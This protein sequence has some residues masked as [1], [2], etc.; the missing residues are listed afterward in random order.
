LRCID[1]ATGQEKWN[2]AYDAP[3]KISHNGSRTAPTVDET[4]VYSVGMM[5]HFYCIDRTTHQPVWAKNLLSDFGVSKPGWG[6]V[7]APS[8]YGDLVIVAPQAADAY[9][10]A[11]NK[12]TGDLVW[13]SAALGVV[14]YSTPVVARLSGVDQAVMVGACTKG[15]G[16]PAKVGGVSLADGS[17]LWTYDGFQCHIPIPYPAVLPDDRLF[18]TGGYGAGSAMI[19]VKLEGEQWTVKELFK[20]EECASQTHQPLFYKDHL[21]VNSNSNEREDGM[22]CLTMDGQVK[23]KTGSS[24][25]ATT[26]ERGP[27]LLVDGVIL[28]LDGK[29]GILHMVDPSPDEY[30]ELAQAP[31]FEG[32]EIW[33]PMAFSDGKLLAR[34]QQELKCLKLK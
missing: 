14:G 27:L 32:K 25:F 33:A 16:N 21:Y 34:N 8:L 23:W 6:V 26:F 22:M 15:G 13:K 7:Q 2:F 28:T 3:G 19:Q 20:T 5:G 1:L 29:E 11:F 17:V 24:W 12:N 4:R 9:V 31:L 10:A 30:K 18:L